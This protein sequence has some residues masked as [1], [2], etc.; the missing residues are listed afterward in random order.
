MKKLAIYIVDDHSLFREGLRFLLSNLDFSGPVYEAGNGTEFLTGLELHPADIALVD[1]EMPEMNGIEATRRALEKKPDLKVIA[2]SMYSDESY[3]SS[4]IEA[5]ASGF[6]L[7]NSGFNEVKKAIEQVYEG[8]TYFSMDILQS[9][10][11]NRTTKNRMQN[12]EPLTEREKEILIYICQGLT[13]ADIADK[14]KLSK[15]TVDKHRENLLLK[16][17]S[18]NTASLVIFAV[19]NGYYNL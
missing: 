19:K 12:E 2:L 11:K 17:N 3:Y 13:N 16:T 7:K 1:I 6:L 9:F 8:K 18:K 14:L 15:R 4:M 5:G 10:M